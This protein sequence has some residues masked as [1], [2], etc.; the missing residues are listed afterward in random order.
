[1]GNIDNMLS[2][3]PFQL[4]S[5]L[6][7]SPL[8]REQ[9]YRTCDYSIG[10]IYMW[11]KYFQYEYCIYNGML[12]M[13]SRVDGRPVF[14]LPVGRGSLE[15][16]IRNLRDYCS[17]KGIS[18]RMIVVPENALSALPAGG[19][20]G[21]TQQ[22]DDYLYL[23]SDLA[24][25]QGHA[26]KNKRNRMTHFVNTYDYSFE[27]LSMENILEAEDFV[28]EFMAQNMEDDNFF[29]D[30][31]NEE[32]LKVLNM[33]TV[34]PF[35]GYIVRVEARIAGIIIGETV[36][37]TLF[38]HIEKANRMFS[39]VNEFLTA[40]FVEEVLRLYPGI[41]HVNREEDMG[42]EGLRRSKLSFNPLRIIEKF[43]VDYE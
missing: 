2:F 38:I 20:T 28:K 17:E 7:I 16:A 32:T 5:I 23:A 26:L 1:M 27:A 11:I 34:F 18:L 43:T 30:Y 21:H 39:G 22:W 29:R 36:N 4:E 37:D 6:S 10:G 12:Y 14:L 35:I 9:S 41:M 31:E 8:I 25:Y 3:D 15:D 24:A 42:D 33:W 19:V 40:R 13:K